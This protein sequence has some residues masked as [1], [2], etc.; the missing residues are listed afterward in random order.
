MVCLGKQMTSKTVRQQNGIH[1]SSL[2]HVGIMLNFY[3][4]PADMHIERMS[5]MQTV[6]SKLITTQAPVCM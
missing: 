6:Y 5:R 2:V 4:M 1:L 3:S